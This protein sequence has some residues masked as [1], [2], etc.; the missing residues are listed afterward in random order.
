MELETQLMI[1]ERLCYVT[2]ESA[3]AVLERS[4]ELGRVLLLNSLE[5]KALIT[6]S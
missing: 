1:S 3:N 5:K 2:R 4:A 6:G